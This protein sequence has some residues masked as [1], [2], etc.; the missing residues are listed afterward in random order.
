[1]HN[2]SCENEFYM[3]E[4]EKSFPYQRLS[5]KLVLIQRPGGTR[6]LAFPV[7]IL[8]VVRNMCENLHYESVYFKEL[9]T[10]TKNHY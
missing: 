2:L 9:Y 10:T 3:Y 1:M 7:F 4:N 8:P 6:N 5:T